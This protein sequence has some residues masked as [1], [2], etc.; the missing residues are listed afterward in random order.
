MS[1]DSFKH[2]EQSLAHCFEAA[3]IA[4]DVLPLSV[5]LNSKD[6]Q[7]V[8]AIFK[9]KLGKVKRKINSNLAFL[10]QK[11]SIFFV[12]PMIN[13]VNLLIWNICGASKID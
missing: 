2:F 4:V 13:Q 6:V 5:S 7:L 9:G 8:E 12:L 3:S 1:I 11:I 10:F